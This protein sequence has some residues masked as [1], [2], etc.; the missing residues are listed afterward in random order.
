MANAFTASSA[1]AIPSSVNSEVTSLVAGVPS[2]TPNA[3]GKVLLD[4]GQVLLSNLGP[5]GRTIYAYP[6]DNGHVCYVMTDLG[7]GCMQ[8]FLVGEPATVS[9]GSAYDPPQSGPPAEL[10]GFTQDNVTGV[11]VVVN[12]TPHDA[13]FGNDAWYYRF[14]DNQTPGTAATALIVTLKDGSTVTVPT[15]MTA[16]PQP[17]S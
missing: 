3:P 11:Q 5:D 2:G 7:E 10:A 12:G 17:T 16:P 8:A 13:V 1:S 4:Q 6:T 14:P 9:G 15:R